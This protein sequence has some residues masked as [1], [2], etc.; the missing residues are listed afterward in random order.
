M[1]AAALCASGAWAARPSA[2]AE[3]ALPGDLGGV[4]LYRAM[5]SSGGVN[6]SMSGN[7]SEEGLL[8]SLGL[9]P[10]GDALPHLNMEALMARL[11]WQQRPQQAIDMVFNLVFPPPPPPPPAASED[12]ASSPARRRAHE[13]QQDAHSGTD[14]DSR[15][16]AAA[17]AAVPQSVIDAAAVTAATYGNGHDHA[18]QHHAGNASSSLPGAG[19]QQQAPLPKHLAH[20]T[21]ANAHPTLQQAVLFLLR[22]PQ[23]VN[24]SFNHINDLAHR[25]VWLAVHQIQAIAKG[26]GACVPPGTVP[27][28]MPPDA[29]AGQQRRQKHRRLHLVDEQP[30]AG[31]EGGGVLHEVGP[32]APCVLADELRTLRWLLT[33]LPRKCGLPLLRRMLVAALLQRRAGMLHAFLPEE[34]RQ[35]MLL[36]LQF[37]ASHRDA[38]THKVRR[39]VEQRSAAACGRRCLPR[40]QMCQHSPLAVLAQSVVEF[41]HISKAGGT[42]MCSLST[43]NGC[44]TWVSAAAVASSRHGGLHRNDASSR[45]VVSALTPS[46]CVMAVVASAVCARACAQDAGEKRNCL[47]YEFDDL[48]HWVSRAAHGQL[49]TNRTWG[50]WFIN[51]ET[52]RNQVFCAR[53]CARHAA[54]L[55]TLP[56]RARRGDVRRRQER[57]QRVLVP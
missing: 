51:Y 27:G 22:S 17:T 21:I 30:A 56:T 8:R 39:R 36:F 10:D 11:I 44:T 23:A 54:P 7:Y 18:P 34:Q 1:L 9:P 57:V 55:F 32:E 3:W 50:A 49:T 5:V 24:Q 43:K 46:L 38:A 52:E 31:A 16:A 29:G 6:T 53:R 47:V 45:S 42:S 28:A 25:P 37:Y 35:I 4:E 12:G 13:Q 14:N 19:Q 2:P 33:Q 41:F 20:L 15:A 26:R 48:P 40:Q